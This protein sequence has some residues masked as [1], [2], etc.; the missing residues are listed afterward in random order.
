MDIRA[1][2]ENHFRNRIHRGVNV[3]C[4][5][6]ELVLATRRDARRSVSETAALHPMGETKNEDRLSG[7]DSARMGGGRTQAPPAKRKRALWGGAVRQSG[8]YP[9]GGSENQATR[10]PGCCAAK[11]GE[12]TTSSRGFPV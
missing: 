10:L 7:I 4:Q 12:T 9:P 8:R 5:L 1:V 2:H 6:V 11:L 3:H